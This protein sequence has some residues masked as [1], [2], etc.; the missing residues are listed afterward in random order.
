M[1]SRQSEMSVENHFPLKKN[2][3][4]GEHPSYILL[5]ITSN[6]LPL[7]NNFKLFILDFSS[8]KQGHSRTWVEALGSQRKGEHSPQSFTCTHVRN[9]ES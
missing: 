7:S 3:P 1:G 4:W 2:L 6:Y 9:M 5:S 8:D